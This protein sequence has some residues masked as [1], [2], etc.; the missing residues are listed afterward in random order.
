LHFLP[1]E[2]IILYG[3]SL[4]AVSTTAA[5][6]ILFTTLVGF[7]GIILNNRPFLAVYTLLLWVCLAFILAPGYMTYKQ[8]TF[9][10]EGKINAQWSRDLGMKGRLRV[11]NALT[12]C[13][14]YSPF[15][16]ATTSNLCYARSILPGCKGKYLRFE[17]D[18]LKYWYI[19]SF[20]LVPLQIAVIITSLLSSSHI[21]Y[22]FGKGLTPK[23]YRLDMQA[24]N[25]LMEEYSS[26]IAGMYGPAVAQEAVNRSASNLSLNEKNSYPQPDS[27]G[28][29]TGVSTLSPA[30][31]RNPFSG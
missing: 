28:L 2:L 7:A 3:K 12:C 16:E 31:H 27:Q 19:A 25:V 15:I 9:N 30:T 20:S 23:R 4:L 1:I 21:T 18:V 8:R 17:R 6:L 29:S 13:G 24:M 10:L 5:S 11:Q 14:Y 22:R 26:Q